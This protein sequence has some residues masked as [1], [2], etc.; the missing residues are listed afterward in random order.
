MFLQTHAERPKSRSSFVSMLFSSTGNNKAADVA[1]PPK[2][3]AGGNSNSNASPTKL[4][5]E[6]ECVRALC[7]VLSYGSCYWYCCP[8]A[9]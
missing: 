3:K 9:T 6:G 4:A 7:V 1:S 2:S 8:R 5:A